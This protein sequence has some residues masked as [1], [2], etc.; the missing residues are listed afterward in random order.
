MDEVKTQERERNNVTL[1]DMVS[2]DEKS[3]DTIGELLYRKTQPNAHA[4][5]MQSI[6][7]EDLS[8]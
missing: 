6:G 1:G 5:T 8:N 7:Y 4:P 2:H 3:R